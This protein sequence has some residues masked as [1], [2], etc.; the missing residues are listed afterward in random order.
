MSATKHVIRIAACASAFITIQPPP[1]VAGMAEPE[2]RARIVYR[3][4]ATS[5]QQGDFLN[6]DIFWCDGDGKETS[7]ALE[8]TEIATS[9]AAAA[10]F[11]FFEKHGVAVG[12]IRTRPVS[13]PA[14]QQALTPAE[15]SSIGL[16]PIM[17]YSLES[18]LANDFV[19]ATTQSSFSLTDVKISSSSF[20]DAF[21]PNYVAV[22]SC[23][24]F[25]GSALFGRLYFQVKSVEQKGDVEK[26]AGS[27]AGR[28]G[29]LSIAADIEVVGSKAPDNSEVRY[30]HPDDADSAKKIASDL[31]S[32]FNNS[33][34][35]K[36]VRGYESKVRN[37]TF[38]AWISNSTP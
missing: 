9:Y 11:E 5:T 22:Y 37:G 36:F 3:N 25:D 14:L 24:D 30:F 32:E 29:G 28:Y 17:K 13:L 33:T 8:A 16:A 23:S 26:V 27:L 10:K 15:F 7:R 4:L 12:E 31:S 38:E 35:P 1:T 18:Q 2:K 6:V 34:S 20:K 21:A 19:Q